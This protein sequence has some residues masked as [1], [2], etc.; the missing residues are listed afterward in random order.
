MVQ[1]LTHPLMF[2]AFIVNWPNTPSLR[3]L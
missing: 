3:I 1:F 2:D